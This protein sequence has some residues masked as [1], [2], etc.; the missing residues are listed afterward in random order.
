MKNIKKIL[1]Y[2]KSSENQI[3]LAAIRILANLLSGNNE[4]T[5]VIDYFNFF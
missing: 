4:Q 3:T 5:N 2:V 1:N